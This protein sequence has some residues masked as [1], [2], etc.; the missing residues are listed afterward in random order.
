MPN[1]FKWDA[2]YL[3]RRILVFF[4]HIYRQQGNADKVLL[5]NEQSKQSDS[6]LFCRVFEYWNT[7]S[8]ADRVYN[9]N[10]PIA[11]QF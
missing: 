8:Y 2:D 4:D 5:E 1:L 10:E 6:K 7:Y 9:A 3:L 11:F